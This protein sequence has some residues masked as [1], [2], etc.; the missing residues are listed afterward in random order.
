MK[1]VWKDIK[2]YEGRYKVSNYGNVYSINNKKILK[3]NI[4]S[5]KRKDGT[6]YQRAYVGLYD[7]DSNYKFIQVHK[8]VAEAFIPNPNNLPTIDHIDINALN[9]RADNLRWANLST[10]MKNRN[11]YNRPANHKVAVVMCDLHTHQ[12]IGV[13]ETQYDIDKY[14]N[15]KNAHKHICDVC[16]GKRKYSY[17]HWWRYLKDNERIED[18]QRII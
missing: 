3:W 1:E 12:D 11:S 10:Q 6:L 14:F 15:N 13:F 5:R 2:G 16:K 18:F 4:N 17:N 8:L 9:N 7:K